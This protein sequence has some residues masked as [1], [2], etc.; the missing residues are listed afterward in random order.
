MKAK[1]LLFLSSLVLLLCSCYSNP[2]MFFE[3]G[4][5]NYNPAPSE[6]PNTTSSIQDNTSVNSSLPNANIELEALPSESFSEVDGNQALVCGN[7]EFIFNKVD[8][9]YEVAVAKTSSHTIT[10]QTDNSVNITVCDDSSLSGVVEAHF[11]TSYQ[12]VEKKNYGYLLSATIETKKKSKFLIEDA[13]YISNS[14]LLSINRYITVLEQNAYETGFQSN[15]VF[16][17]ATNSTDYQKFDYFLPG[18]IYKDTSQ[19]AAGICSNLNTS[20]VYVKETRTGLP[21]IMLRNKENTNGLAL[22]HLEPKIDIG[23]TNGGG[24]GEISNELQYGSLGFHMKDPK[25]G[26]GFTYPAYEGPYSYDTKGTVSRYHRIQKGYCHSYKLGVIPTNAST[27]NDAMI[28]SYQS[29]YNADEKY[30]ADINIDTVYEQNMEIYKNEYRE[31]KYNNSVVS[32]GMPFSLSLP[33]GTIDEGISFAMGFIG[34]QIPVGF[35]LYRY[36]VLNNDNATKVKGENILNFWSNSGVNSTYF[37]NIWYDP[38]SN[39]TGG[40]PRNMPIYLRYIVD[41]MEGFIDA[42]AF[43]KRHGVQKNNWYNALT[44]TASNLV[45]KQNSDGSFYRAYN[46]DGSVCLDTSDRRTQGDSPYNT[47]IAVRF[48]AKMWELTGDAKYKNAALKAAEYSYNALYKGLCKYVGGTPDNPNTVD[49]EAAVYA[50]YCFTSAYML[51]GDAKYLDAAE[52]AAICALSWTFAYDFK[53]PNSKADDFGKNPF[54]DGGVIGF[55]LIATGHGGADNYSAYTYF[56]TYKLY[57]LT[58]KEFY[59]NAALLLQ[60]DTK[61]SSDYDGTLGYKYRALTPEATTVS[62]F[63]FATVGTWLTWQGIANIEPIV[64][65]MDAFGTGDIY[66]I[67]GSFNEQLVKINDFGCGGKI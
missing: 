53:V 5:S 52:H 8:N 25:A 17:E 59:K 41:G 33:D 54:T 27:Y 13:Y 37:P 26:I 43:A 57:L 30:I 49:K 6:N 46:R 65:C 38:A 11:S 16:Y 51:T 58:G 40:N 34:Q 39:S 7:Y 3:S 20:K 44:R 31:Y 45:S 1:N 22:Y 61:L 64:D 2:P 9:G 32:A 42:Y 10:F 55:S 63:T 66:K 24:L 35:H 36:G 56:E 47:P 18:I 15:I 23:T 19:M 62:D 50:M 4:F 48:L 60:N 12:S 28:N 21:V 14:N 67:Q 29:A